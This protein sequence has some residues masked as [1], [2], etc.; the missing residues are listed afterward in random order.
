MILLLILLFIH[1][2]PL[3][4]FNRLFCIYHSTLTFLPRLF[5][6]IPWYCHF[7]RLYNLNYILLYCLSFIC[8]FIILRFTTLLFTYYIFITLF[9]YCLWAKIFCNSFDF[10]MIICPGL[11]FFVSSFSIQHLQSFFPLSR[12]LS[13]VFSLLTHPS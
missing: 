7:G 1:V 5:Y 6:S 2:L 12:G 11:E 3:F 4:Q 8:G 10:E 9:I 13:A